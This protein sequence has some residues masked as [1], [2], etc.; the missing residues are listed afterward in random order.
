[1]SEEDTTSTDTINQSGAVAPLDPTVVPVID[2]DQSDVVVPAALE[3]VSVEASPEL[4]PVETPEPVASDV[5][6]EPQPAVGAEPEVAPAPDGATE[7]QSVSSSDLSAEPPQ[8]ASAVQPEAKTQLPDASSPS[9]E[10]EPA[11]QKQS[12][13]EVREVVVEK[14]KPLTDADKE[15]IFA[16]RLKGHLTSAQRAKRGNYEKHLQEILAFIRAR[17]TLVTNQDI[18]EGLHIPDSTV[19]DRLNVL[20]RRGL[21]V[22]LGDQRHAKYKLTGAL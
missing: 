21:I 20:V 8:S 6:V 2:T 11:P 13:S 3:T 17:G 10:Q 14:E 22:R 15:A 16:E 9:Q 1:M 12:A 5:V 19:T 18:E 7:P 4:V